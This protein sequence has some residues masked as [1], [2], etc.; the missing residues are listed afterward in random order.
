ALHKALGVIDDIA[1][2]ENET[3][4]I[5]GRAVEGTSARCRETIDV[6]CDILGGF[7]GDV[8]LMT[9]SRGGVYIGGGIA[10]RIINILGQSQFRSRF[11][12]KGRMSEF[13]RNI[14]THVITASN[15]ALKGAAMLL[16]QGV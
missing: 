3:P 9:G 11:E 8:A 12:D 5:I 7:A 13:V 15:P 6:F 10:P 2:S 1:P 16:N 14:P 4:D